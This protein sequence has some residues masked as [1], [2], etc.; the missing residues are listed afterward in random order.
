MWQLM[1]VKTRKGIE[2][3]ILGSRIS[4]LA[5]HAAYRINNLPKSEKLSINIQGSKE[6]PL[7]VWLVV[8]LDEKRPAEAKAKKYFVAD[9]EKDICVEYSVKINL[10]AEMKAFSGTLKKLCRSNIGQ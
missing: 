3:M 8:P 4:R 6:G 7:T 1:Q 5:P 2:V 10:A 9:G